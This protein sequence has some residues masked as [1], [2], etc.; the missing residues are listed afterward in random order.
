MSLKDIYDL[1]TSNVYYKLK[2]FT[3]T[4]VY[5]Q[6]NTR[7]GSR[8][9]FFSLEDIR[10]ANSINDLDID[11]DY[12]YDS[13]FKHGRIVFDD[14]ILAE[15]NMQAFIDA[16]SPVVIYD[17]FTYQENPNILYLEWYRGGAYDDSLITVNSESSNYLD[18][19]LTAAVLNPNGAIKYYNHY[20]TALYEDEVFDYFI[21]YQVRVLNRYAG[22]YRGPGRRYQVLA[23][24]ID[25]DTYTITEER[26]GWGR[27][28]EYPIGWILLN[29]T[30]RIVGPGQNP[31]YD[32]AGQETA[33]IP[34]MSHI[35]ITKM[36]VDRLW[37]YCPEQESW[38]KTED[39]SFDQQ[40]KLYS[41]LAIQ[42]IDLEEVNWTT[43]AAQQTLT[44]VGINPNAY[45]LRFHDLA[46]YTYSG[47]Y[48][49]A[50][51]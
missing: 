15:D 50:A 17:K 32:V 25:Q 46:S 40:G 48:N 2:T 12:Y 36:T 4:I 6:N 1:G 35:N 44:S 26:N 7:V 42:V 27:L 29:Q 47:Q 38:I 49:K 30:E 8:D 37:A 45:W 18:C 13:N 22:I 19:D 31:E 28:R 20:H 34:F 43:V 39:I 21:P 11:V 24:I 41:G 3:K 51:F 14:S 23:M 5:Y 33:T 10:N 16:P 9:V